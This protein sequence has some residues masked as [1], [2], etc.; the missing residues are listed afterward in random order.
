MHYE[1]VL[2]RRENRRRFLQRLYELSEE[3]TEVYENGYALADLLGLA[4]QDAERIA[5]YYEDYGFVKN[6][7][8]SGLVLRITAAGIDHV[9]AEI[10]A[11]HSP[12]IIET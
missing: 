10:L 8:G 5:R 1:Q 4:R 12:P 11:G 7:G 3:G 2:Q 6:T 9:E